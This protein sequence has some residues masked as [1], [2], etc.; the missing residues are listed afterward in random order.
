M[1]KSNIKERAPD[2]NKQAT[3]SARVLDLCLPRPLLRTNPGAINA[4]F[5]PSITHGT[6]NIHLPATNQVTCVILCT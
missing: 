1:H 3:G 5:H 6:S 4:H 2:I